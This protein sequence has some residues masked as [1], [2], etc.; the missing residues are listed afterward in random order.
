MNYKVFQ[1]GVLEEV[2]RRAGADVRNCLLLID[3]SS[4]EI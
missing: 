1:K 2:K 4:N 3:S